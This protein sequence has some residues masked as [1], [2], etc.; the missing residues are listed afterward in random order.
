VA[1]R[2]GY[3]ALI[4]D[5]ERPAYQLAQFLMRPDLNGKVIQSFFISDKLSEAYAQAEQSDFIYIDPF[6]FGLAESVRFIAEVQAHW[7]VKAFTLFRSGRQ[8]QERQRD[9]EGLALTPA[10]LRTMLALDKD[11]MGDAAFAQAVR[12]N[13]ASMEREFQQEL[14]RTGFDPARSGLVDPGV[15]RVGAWYTVPDYPSPPTPYRPIPGVE[16]GGYGGAN[17]GPMTPAQLQAMIEQAVAAIVRPAPNPTHPLGAPAGTPLLPAPEA[18]Q[19][20]QIAPQVQQNVAALQQNVSTLQSAVAAVQSAQTR[21]QEQ[22]TATG[23]EL[24]DYSRATSGLEQRVRDIETR[25]PRLDEQG[26]RLQ[27]RQRIALILAIL[28]VALGLA[29]LALGL[30]AYLR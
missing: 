14:Q 7:P 28:A 16:Y 24:R 20:Q 30:L 21:T 9:I 19:W 3:R 29:G 2:V 8:W 4:V 17:L 26:A 18:A 22:V 6:S 23:R 13:I 25:L 5:D 10:R 27:N 15:P 1:T 12:N 11:V